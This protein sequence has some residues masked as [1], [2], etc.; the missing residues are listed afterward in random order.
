[1]TKTRLTTV[2]CVFLLA[3]AGGCGDAGSPA[4]ASGLPADQKLSTLD[5][6]GVK[7]LCSSLA[8]GFNHAYGAAEKKRF[9]CNALAIPLSIDDSNPSQPRGDVAMC[10]QLVTRCLNGESISSEKPPLDPDADVFDTAQCDE[11][12]GT[13]TELKQCAANVSSFEGCANALLDE[14]VR[15]LSIIDCD[16]LV[17]VDRLKAMATADLDISG[18]P[19]CKVLTSQCPDLELV[20]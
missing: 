11:A 8:D 13:G 14:S 5:D 6:P 1:M 9:N 7:R 16:G 4:I 3:W 12:Q 18:L 10:K 20:D 17:D 15:R 2:A 19:E